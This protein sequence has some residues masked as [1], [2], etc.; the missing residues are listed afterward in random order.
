MRGAPVS[1]AEATHE[2]EAAF[3]PITILSMSA[4]E[5]R[6]I[7]SDVF[8]ARVEATLGPVLSAEGFAAA[9]NSP[10]ELHFQRDRVLVTVRWD[11]PRVGELSIVIG[12]EDSK[13]PP[14]ELDD[15]LEVSDLP[16]KDLWLARMQTH[17]ADA[18]SR[19]LTRATELLMSHAKPLLRG[20]EKSIAKAYAARAERSQEYTKRVSVGSRTLDAAD[21]AWQQ[22]DYDRV[23]AL[24]GPVRD[25]LDKARRRRLDFAERRTGERAEG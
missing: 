2:S 4:A 12:A 22:K 11:G 1:Q 23:L 25:R 16:K 6:A 18:L 20:D 21:A 9:G 13:E 3:D 8:A 5:G 7:T 14:L 17:D 24:L 19:L 10:F 15:V